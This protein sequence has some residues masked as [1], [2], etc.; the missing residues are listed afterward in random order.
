MSK[1]PLATIGKFLSPFGV[2]GAV[3]VFP[4]S[5]FLERCS[6][7]HDVIVEQGGQRA[8]H[9]VKDARVYKN[10]WVMQLEGIYSREE[11]ARLNGALLKIPADQRVTL[12]EGS[13]YLDE[14]IGLA[15]LSVTGEKLGVVRDVLKTGGNDIYVVERAAAAGEKLRREILVPAIH[16]VVK[17][18]NL[19]KGH[20][21]LELPPGLMD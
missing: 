15:A 3:K 5:D 18:I 19:E 10:L 7:L 14:I 20:I 16:N 6:E 12:P 1:E 13:Y 17:E 8:N 4:Y 11:A 9:R 21:L 2:A